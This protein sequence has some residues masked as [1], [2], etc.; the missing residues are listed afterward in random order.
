MANLLRYA[1]SLG[2]S[3]IPGAQTIPVG[4]VIR[5]PFPL[6]RLKFSQLPP[7]VETLSLVMVNRWVGL[8]TLQLLCLIPPA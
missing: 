4:R 7:G 8:G 2:D 5:K 3:R 1:I 6:F